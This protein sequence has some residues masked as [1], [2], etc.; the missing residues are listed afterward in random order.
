MCLFKAKTFFQKI[1][2]SLTFGN[3]LIETLPGTIIKK[4]IFN[5]LGEFLNIRAG[6]DLEWFQRIIQK[7]EKSYISRNCNIIYQGFPNKLTELITKW[8][9]YSFSN[10]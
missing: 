2:K 4:S 7:N 8:F 6:E 1:V 10:Y 9:I 3:K 5:N